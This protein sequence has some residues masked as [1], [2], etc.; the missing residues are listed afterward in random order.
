[1]SVAEGKRLKP[2]DVL[3]MLPLQG[4]TLDLSEYKSVERGAGGLLANLLLTRY[5]DIE[6]TVRPPSNESAWKT[7]AETGILWGLENRN[8]HTDYAQFPE[9]PE[10]DEWQNAWTIGNRQLTL[11]LF[12]NHRNLEPRVFSNTHA[13]FVNAHRAGTRVATS[14]IRSTTKRWL[15]KMIPLRN[16]SDNDQSI[17]NDFLRDLGELIEELVS[18][19]C[20]HAGSQC[21]SL[22]LVTRARTSDRSRHRIHVIVSDT[23]PGI[24]QTARAKVASGIPISSVALLRGLLDGT[25]LRGRRAAGEGLPLVTSFAR[26]HPKARLRVTANGVVASVNAKSLHVEDE[27]EEIGGTVIVLTVPLPVVPHGQQ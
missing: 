3:R 20:L 2:D 7:L 19:V 10:L 12:N 21:S 15:S 26:S 22:V 24:L 1:M 8:A 18:N 11:G 16:L 4:G 14:G 6:L 23:G 5:Q 25:V 9:T 17:R 27:E 13:A